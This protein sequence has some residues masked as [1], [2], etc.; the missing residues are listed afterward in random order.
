MTHPGKRGI[1]VHVHPSNYTMLDLFL[2]LSKSNICARATFGCLKTSRIEAPIH[3]LHY[4]IAT[5]PQP[6]YFK[7]FSLL[8]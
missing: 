3:L 4:E 8:W 1:T 7:A 2:S 6:L 5:I